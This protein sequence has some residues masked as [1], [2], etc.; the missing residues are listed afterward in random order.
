[1][2]DTMKARTYFASM[3]DRDLRRAWR[4]QLIATSRPALWA[5]LRR[6]GLADEADCA[7]KIHAHEEGK[8]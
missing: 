2:G 6:R 8:P 5:E 4:R 7:E 1:M 3:P